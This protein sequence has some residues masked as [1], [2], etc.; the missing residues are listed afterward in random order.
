MKRFKP[1]AC[2][3]YKSVDDDG[4]VNYGLDYFGAKWG[5]DKW[6]EWMSQE[7]IDIRDDYILETTSF[8]H[9]NGII[10]ED[11]DEFFPHY[12]ISLP[13]YESWRK[14]I[15]DAHH[16]IIE[17]IDKSLKPGGNDP[18]TGECRCWVYKD[19]EGVF[20]YTLYRCAEIGER[21]CKSDSSIDISNVDICL[22]KDSLVCVKIDLIR[23][24]YHIDEAVYNE[25]M[26]IF[27]ELCLRLFTEIQQTIDSREAEY[28]YLGL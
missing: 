4:V 14:L 25:V 11:S 23:E 5:V 28:P 8:P 22:D 3:A 21:F 26:Q 18:Y 17:L 1:F 24:S 10:K 20:S 12:R 2:Y 16:R 27:D 6:G 13:E 15:Y 7:H 9:K 19:D